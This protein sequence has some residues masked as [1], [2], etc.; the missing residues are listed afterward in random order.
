MGR[1][2]TRR[3]VSGSLTT[4]YQLPLYPRG[5]HLTLS[6]NTMC[7]LLKPLFITTT[8]TNRRIL[9][10]VT[11]EEIV[12]HETKFTDFNISAIASCLSL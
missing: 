12:P 3:D 2:A 6:S 8:R 5:Y 10:F 11:A 7:V 1:V 9:L 4:P